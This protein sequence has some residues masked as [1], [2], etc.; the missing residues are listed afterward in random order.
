MRILILN[1]PNIN[2]IGF[3][4]PSIYGTKTYRDLC[5]FL[6]QKGKSFHQKIKIKQSNYEG[7]LITQLQKASQKF[8]YVILNAGGFTHT[9]I[10]LK[11][12][13]AC[14]LIPVIEVHLSDVDHREDFRKINFIRNQCECSFYGKGFLSYEEALLYIQ[15]KEKKEV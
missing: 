15:T 9:S 13:I 3:R 1:G 12:A 5:H 6:K 11:D 7:Y 4:E 14:C 8:D 2:Q 10:A